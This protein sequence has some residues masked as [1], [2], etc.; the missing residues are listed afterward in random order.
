MVVEQ[1]GRRVDGSRQQ[2]AA[3]RRPISSRQLDPR[4][5]G[6]VI[7]GRAAAAA[8]DAGVML[9]VP[10]AAASLAAV[11]TGDHPAARR[12]RDAM[13]T[14]VEPDGRQL[15]H[16]RRLDALLNAAAADTMGRRR[17]RVG[18]GNGLR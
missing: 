2:R 13:S 12:I 17:R 5:D 10:D 18:Y 9:V 1:T 8:D 14:A 4:R 3:V 7:G 16:R 6:E 15:G 11:V